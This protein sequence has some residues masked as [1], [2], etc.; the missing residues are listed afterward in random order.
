MKE[1]M[2]R[3]A[4]ALLLGI[5]LISASF[6]AQKKEP[7]EAK[8]SGTIASF[9]DTSVVLSTGRMGQKKETTFVLNPESKR[10]GTLATGKRATVQYHMQ[11][12]EKIATL[13]QV[14]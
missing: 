11:G 3:A 10:E 13:V 12:G 6:A 4:T 9:T 7:K 14:K 8:A 1:P 2:K 5:L